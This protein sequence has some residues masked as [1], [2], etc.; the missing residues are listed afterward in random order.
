MHIEELI[1]HEMGIEK[2]PEMYHK[3]ASSDE[4]FLGTVFQW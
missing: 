3:L 1:T 4:D 2:A